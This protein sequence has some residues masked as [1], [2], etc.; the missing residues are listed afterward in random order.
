[1]MSNVELRHLR[2]FATVAEEKNI[3]RAAARLFVTQPALSRQIK[4]LEKLLGVA[5]FVR[6]SSGLSLTPAGQAFLPQARQILEQ[7]AEAMLSMRRFIECR[8]HSLAVGYIA[9][10]LGSFLGAALQV[11]RQRHP[12]LEVKLFELPPGRQIEALRE[13]RLDI[14]LIGHACPELRREFELVTIRRIPLVAALSATHPLA[15]R[16][17]IKLSELKHEVFIGLDEATFPGRNEV[18]RA[19]CRKAGFTPRIAHEA[20]GLSTVLALIGSGSGVG[21]MP[22]EVQ[23]LPY[24]NVLFKPLRAP[25]RHI[26]FCAALCIGEKRPAVRAISEEFRSAIEIPP[27][28]RTDS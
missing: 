18:I 4:D 9:P 26:N 16:A 7:S 6:A 12:Q 10:A 24:S 8:N 27:N 20:D 1:M 11:F 3:T 13:G 25:Q 14:A 21:I 5:L 22:D 17:A 28:E 15:R 2:Y 23:Q 19:V